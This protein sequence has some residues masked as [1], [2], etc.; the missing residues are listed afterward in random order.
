M[1]ILKIENLTVE[2]ENKINKG[3]EYISKVLEKESK[4]NDQKC[5]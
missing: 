5:L 3:F 1:H 4:I 2:I